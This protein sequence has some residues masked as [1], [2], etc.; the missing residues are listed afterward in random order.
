[1][2]DYYGNVNDQLAR[3]EARLGA[4]VLGGMSLLHEWT[5]AGSRVMWVRPEYVAVMGRREGVPLLLRW[6]RATLA[7]QIRS[8]RTQYVIASRQ[9]KNDLATDAA[10]A[11]LWI[12]K[13]LPE[14]L[15]PQAALPDAQQGDF[16]LLR[17][18]PARLERY[19]RDTEGAPPG[20]PGPAR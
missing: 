7:R 16:V 3:E 12:A 8:T 1:M 4:S 14:Y 13:D 5:P 2:K 10:D 6:D 20:P 15:V 17:V 19:I 9:Y 11:F 18:D